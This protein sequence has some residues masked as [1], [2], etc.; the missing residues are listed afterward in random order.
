[1]KKKHHLFKGGM[2]TFAVVGSLVYFGT[3]FARTESTS[4]TLDSGTEA[5]NCGY[6]GNSSDHC[7]ASDGS[8]NYQILQCAPSTSGG[9]YY[10]TVN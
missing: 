4:V 2:L 10:D 5:A 3:A 8:H 1:M 6:T 9:C 7:S